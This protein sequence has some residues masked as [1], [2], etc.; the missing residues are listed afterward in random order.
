MA[1]PIG[2]RPKGEEFVKQHNFSKEGGE[3]P[4]RFP[5][6]KIFDVK[7]RLDFDANPSFQDPSSKKI[8]DKLRRFIF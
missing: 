2:G 6:Q 5:D 7:R 3:L 4:T 1:A 8:N